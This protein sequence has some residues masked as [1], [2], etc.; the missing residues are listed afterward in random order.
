[1]AT[2]KTDMMLP[3]RESVPFMNPDFVG[4]A[5]N[6]NFMLFMTHRKSMYIETKSGANHSELIHLE[7]I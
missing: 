7:N 2:V 3:T 4:A 1:M 5:T 6:G